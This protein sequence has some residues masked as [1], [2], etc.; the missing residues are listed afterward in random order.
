MDSPAAIEALGAQALGV[1]ANVTQASEVERL[2]QETLGRFGKVDI[3]VN[4]AGVV[5]V[6]SIMS[7]C[8][9]EGS[10]WAQNPPPFAF[11][12]DGGLPRSVH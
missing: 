1:Q 7:K 11:R 12:R 8:E 4:N 6:K 10:C 5:V 2:V 9:R 3:L